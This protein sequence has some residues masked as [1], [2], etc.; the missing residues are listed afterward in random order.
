MNKSNKISSFRDF[1]PRYLRAHSSPISLAFHFGGLLASVALAVALVSCGMVFFL[2]LAIVPAQLGA[3]IGHKLSPRQEH[4]E[5]HP[6]WAAVADVKMF[7]LFLTGRLGTELARTRELVS[8]PSH[9]SGS[10]RRSQPP[11][12][13]AGGAGAPRGAFDTARAAAFYIC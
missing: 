13:A 2:L 10:A 9:P 11:E 5:E 4:I 8:A 6:D 3:W 1:W 7:G 12:N